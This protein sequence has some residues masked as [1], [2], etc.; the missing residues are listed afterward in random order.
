MERS[1][2]RVLADS[3]VAAVAIAVLLLWSLDSAF[4]GLWDPVYRLGVFLLTAIAIRDIPY[5]PPT[6]TAADHFMLIS[7]SYFLY[8]AIASLSAAW[9]LSRWVY[10]TGPLCS[11]ARCR[12]KLVVRNH[13]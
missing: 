6:P 4:R 2:R 1:L 5:L 8:S 10:G 12:S 7:S 13:A 11:L 9:L 3:Y